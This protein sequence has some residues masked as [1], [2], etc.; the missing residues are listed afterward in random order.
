MF[1]TGKNNLIIIMATCS[2]G[3]K[4]NMFTFEYLLIS[5]VLSKSETFKDFGVTFDLKVSFISNL[6]NRYKGQL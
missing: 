2:A 5:C 4:S 1:S 3:W 6:N